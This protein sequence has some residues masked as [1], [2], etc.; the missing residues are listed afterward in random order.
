MA[1]K[2]IA[3]S[4]YCIFHTVAQTVACRFTF[5]CPCITP[6]LQYTFGSR[7][8]SLSKAC[9]MNKEPKCTEIRKRL[10]SKN[11]TQICLNKGGACQAGIV[12]HQPQMITIGGNPPQRGVLHI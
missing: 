6:P 8:A 7:G 12:S 1:K 11:V 5:L 2:A 10:V 4:K 9:R 3:Q